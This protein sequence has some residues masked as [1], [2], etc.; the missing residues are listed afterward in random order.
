MYPGFSAGIVSRVSP[1]STASPAASL[2]AS[3]DP[4]MLGSLQR[5]ALSCLQ[6]PTPGE[7]FCVSIRFISVVGRCAELLLFFCLQVLQT[8]SVQHL[9]MSYPFQSLLSGDPAFLLP[10]PHLPRPPTHLSHHPPHL[11]QPGQFGPYPTQQA[12]SVSR[13]FFFSLGSHAMHV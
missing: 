3:A 13:I 6:R 9:P 2:S 7:C 12:R 1:W 8:C 11:P 4:S 5:A 10:P